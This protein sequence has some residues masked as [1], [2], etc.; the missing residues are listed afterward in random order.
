[1]W[2]LPFEEVSL[3]VV[4]AVVVVFAVDVVVVEVIVV[5]AEISPKIVD[6]LLL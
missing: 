1:M 3:A 5:D 2:R 4:S 6:I